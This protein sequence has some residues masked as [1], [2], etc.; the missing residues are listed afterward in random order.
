MKK[1]ISFVA[2]DCFPEDDGES[3]S[4]GSMDISVCD[5]FDSFVDFMDGLLE[6][7]KSNEQ[8]EDDFR[9]IRKMCIELPRHNVFLTYV[10][11]FSQSGH[12]T[13]QYAA[14]KISD[15]TRAGLDALDQAA[16]DESQNLVGRFNLNLSMVFRD[17]LP[18]LGWSPPDDRPTVVY[19]LGCGSML[20]QF[21][22]HK[23]IPNCQLIG[24]DGNATCISSFDEHRKNGTGFTKFGD[25]VMVGD[26]VDEKT[27]KDLAKPDIILIRHQHS[28]TTPDFYKMAL[29]HL[30]DAHPR[31]LVMVTSFSLYEH[32]FFKK[33]LRRWQRR[34]PSFFDFKIVADL[35][36]TY[37]NP[38]LTDQHVLIIRLETTPTVEVGEKPPRE[39]GLDAENRDKEKMSKQRRPKFKI[40]GL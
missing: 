24:I 37:G 22:L 36:L 18:S 11:M 8:F 17:T 26:A 34:N 12:L 14:T 40:S 30:D 27:Y 5:D 31:R 15:A 9:Q 33:G 32:G 39:K 7:A 10:S 28:L 1:Y 38:C 29:M 21:F 16:S 6:A 3:S 19:S 2:A 13:R 25:K 4:G 23:Q 20:E 35:N